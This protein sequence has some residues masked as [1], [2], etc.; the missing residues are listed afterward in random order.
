MAD[1]FKSLG[2]VIDSYHPDNQKKPTGDGFPATSRS[3]ANAQNAVRPAESKGRVLE[4]IESAADYYSPKVYSVLTFYSNFTHSDDAISDDFIP[5][6][7]VKPNAKMFVVGLIPPAAHLTKKLLDRSAS[8]SNIAGPRIDAPEARATNGG[9]ALV[10]VR[11]G[12][13]PGNNQ[14]Q[15]T[16]RTP[17]SKAQFAAALLKIL[18]NATKEQAGIFYA[19]FSGEC[20]ENSCWGYNLGNVKHGKGSSL[21]YQ[22]LDRVWEGVPPGSVQSHLD[23]GLW[24]LDSNPGHQKAVAP[25]TAIIC[26]PGKAKDNPACYFNTYPDLDTAMASFI[27]SKRT[28]R[29]A[30]AW[31]HIEN[32]DVD[33][34]ARALGA[35]GYYT[36]NPDKYSA[37]MQKH[38]QRWLNDPAFEKA[39]QKAGITSETS[40]GDWQDD[41]AKSASDSREADSKTKDNGYADKVNAI[42]TNLLAAQRQEQEETARR[43]EEM[44]NTP[45][46]RMLVNPASFKNSSEKIISDGGWTRN[47]PVIE[48]W[49]DNQDKIEASGKIAGFFAIDA[50]NPRPDAA[51][52][53]PGLTRVARNF[54]ASYHN[55]LSLWLLYRNN[56]SLHIGSKRE[57]GKD[58]NRISMVGSMYIYYDDIL[59]IGSFDSFNI[60]ETDDKPYTLEYNF[61]FTVRAS[62]LLDRPDKYL[63]NGSWSK[64]PIGTTGG[65]STG[66]PSD[67][68]SIGGGPVAAPVNTTG[69]SAEQIAQFDAENALLGLPR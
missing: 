34:Y 13:V 4:Q 48:H 15:E 53:A 41:G 11:D 3:G 46:L 45:P 52:E 67:L 14:L 66:L 65:G 57:G 2:E 28:G 39:Q 7:Q 42:E 26:A 61:S 12:K 27:N 32:G 58:W 55:F 47:G 37:A 29:Y 19:Q 9:S 23:T 24:V 30:D 51:G 36:A 6:T 5:V 38:Y 43:L 62:F 56:A 54:S 50:N 60:T 40:A 35:K 21:N 69:L 22:A 8:V 59:Y 63:E 25:K 33:G 1:F 31:Q 68:S 16:K 18:P 49:G 20:G 64:P 10:P 17:V 44:K